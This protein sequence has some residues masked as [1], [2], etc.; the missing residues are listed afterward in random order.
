[1]KILTI[2][3][4]AFLATLASNAHSQEKGTTVESLLKIQDKKILEHKLDS[5]I[6]ANEKGIYTVINYY[7]EKRDYTRYDSVSALMPTLY[8][9]GR[10]GSISMVR[11]IAELK[12]LKEVKDSVASFEQKYDKEFLDD[13]YLSAGIAFSK[14][15]ASLPETVAYVNKIKKTLQRITAALN[16]ARYMEFHQ[17]DLLEGYLKSEAKWRAKNLSAAEINNQNYVPIFQDMEYAYSR[18]LQKQGNTV[19]ALAVA[20]KAYEIPIESMPEEQLYYL[21]LLFKQEQYED[22]FPIVDALVKQGKGTI[23]LKQQLATAYEKVYKKDAQAYIAEIEKNLNDA[24]EKDIVKYSVTQ[25]V[26]DFEVLDTKGNKVSIADFRGKTIVIDFWATWCGPCKKSL[27]AMQRTA[28]LYK[29]DKDVAF[30]FIH[31]WGRSEGS[32]AEAVKYFKDNNYD[33]DLYMDNKQ[34]DGSFK[35]AEAFKVRGIPQKYVVDKNGVIRFVAAGFSGG[36]E[37][38]VVQLQ[39][40]IGKTKK[41]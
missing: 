12:D 33:M 27:P 4:V 10:A 11:S 35:A 3:S 16:T 28:N 36:E 6:H 5:L 29:E 13:A 23:E 18:L 19:E 26:P 7:A 8:P 24:V 14:Q 17:S 1:M 15:K 38:A 22:A 31:T 37:A 9:Y 20:R 34:D 2:C 30:L 41:F 21:G 25:Q 40:M 32:L 39:S